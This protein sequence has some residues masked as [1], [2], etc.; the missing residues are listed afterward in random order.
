[1]IKMENFMLCI[2]YTNFSVVNVQKKKKM[3]G[4]ELIVLNK[5]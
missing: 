5:K 3:E 2:F 1:M 4:D